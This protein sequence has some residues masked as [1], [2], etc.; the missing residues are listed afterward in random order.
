MGR[1]KKEENTDVRIGIEPDIFMS[2][3]NRT[4]A[5]AVCTN[6]SMIPIV[7]C[8]DEFG[9]KGT[10]LV[11]FLMRMAALQTQ[12]ENGEFDIDDVIGEAV[13]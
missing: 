11:M 12:Y 1:K 5:E 3:V 6:E 10:R 2:H 9:I 7:K 4:I 13:K 8:L